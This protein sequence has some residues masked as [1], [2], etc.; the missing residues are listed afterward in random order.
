MRTEQTVE[1]KVAYVWDC[2][3]CGAENFERAVVY[4]FSPEEK[5]ECAGESGDV[6]TT[7]HWMSHPT[8]VVCRQ[9]HRKFH[10]QS[11]GSDQQAEGAE[12]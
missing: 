9:C 6:P 7:G 8:E 1:M 3:S 5:A 4:E 12:E 2:E 11:F 10:A